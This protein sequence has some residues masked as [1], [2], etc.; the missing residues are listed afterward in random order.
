M[1]VS[2]TPELEAFVR[3]KVGTG[4]YNNASEVVREALRLLRERSSLQ[5]PPSVEG[6]T[7][8]I[9]SM[10]H[11]LRSVGIAGLSIFGSVARGDATPDSD[12]DILIEVDPQA[13]FSLFD[14]A[15]LHDRLSRKL[16]RR[17][18]VIMA[19]SLRPEIKDSV[20]RE[21]KRIF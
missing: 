9:G 10:H 7:E 18:D 4:T 6:V 16:G 11:E 3:T 5:D 21:A 1:N 14:L 17:V 13:R 15:G 12:V 8:V 20:L 2:L 19:N